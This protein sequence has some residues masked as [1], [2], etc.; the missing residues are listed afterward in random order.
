MIHFRVAIWNWSW[1]FPKWCWPSISNRI[2]SNVL[3]T[4][5]VVGALVY[6]YTTSR[7]PSRIARNAAKS[8][9]PGCF[10]Y[11]LSSI[12]SILS[13]KNCACLFS[14][15]WKEVTL[16]A[17]RGHRW[18]QREGNV[19]AEDEGKTQDAESVSP[20]SYWYS[21]TYQMSGLTESF[22]TILK[23]FFQ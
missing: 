13:R 23:I 19:L 10:I 6:F 4:S 11:V 9:H 21:D 5:S 14:I 17:K 3:L 8:K 22:V 16:D 7:R 18:R 20:W 1:P 2:L 15:V 12:T